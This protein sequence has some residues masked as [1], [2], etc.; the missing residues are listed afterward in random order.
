MKRLITHSLFGLLLAL[1]A[2]AQDPAPPSVPAGLPAIK[3][4]SPKATLTTFLSAMNDYRKGVK[5]D[6]ARLEE[7]L[8]DA[9]HCLNLSGLDAGKREFHGEIAAIH[10][11]EVI[12]RIATLKS[13]AIPSASTDRW[14]LDDTA[15]TIAK[16]SSGDRA[17]EYLFT[18]ETVRRARSLYRQVSHLPYKESSG[19]G[20]LLNWKTKQPAV[21]GE[22][23]I[24]KD[25]ARFTMKT[26]M[27]A[28]EDYRKGINEGDDELTDRIDA[29]VSC[30]SL[31]DVPSVVREDKGRET[32]IYLKE[33]IDRIIA[34]DYD[35]IPV[36]DHNGN[37]VLRFR[38]KSSNE[39]VVIA[40]IESGDQTGE[41]LFT[42][43]TVDGIKSFYNQIKDRPYKTGTGG[44]AHYRPDM[45]ERMVPE[46]LRGKYIL[47]QNWQ[48]AGLFLGILLGLVVKTI[49]QHMT[50]LVKKFTKKSKTDWDDKIVGAIE[51][52]IG[53]L[54]AGAFW[55]FTVHAL[56]FE[57]SALAVLKIIIQVVISVAFIWALY[58]LAD[59]LA[60]YLRKLT[61]KTD[62]MLDDHLVPLIK[63]ALHTFIVIF[64]VLI[65]VQ[66][67]GFNVMSLLAGL[68]L[69]GLAFA[70]AAK[71]TC[72]NFFGSIMILTDR[73]FLV[74]DAVEIGGVSGTVEQIG[75][76]STRLRTFYDSEVTIPNASLANANI[77]NL[78]RRQYRRQVMTLGLTYDTPPEKMEAFAEGVK[79]I[80]KN[81]P[82]T[83]KD[84][85]HVVFESYGDCSLNV[86]VYY[87][88]ETSS[89]SEELVERHNINLQILQLGAE[90]G[91]EFA[92]P[93]QTLHMETFPE[94]EPTR[95]VPP[96]TVDEVKDVAASF[97]KDG[98]NAQPD[99]S[100]IFLPPHKDPD[101]SKK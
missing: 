42:K 65:T 97:G 4:D 81:N 10:L 18:G 76:R 95:T 79:N 75:F 6:D 32:A 9:I 94:K 50:H 23:F 44:G 3:T 70:L 77:D 28:M 22:V 33:V 29:A 62:T 66:N 47:F 64:G 91:V 83:R 71:D 52:P 26:F 101:L 82:I 74:G 34:I 41:Y 49:V 45:V 20:A 85:F 30:L 96:F 63:R 89:R 84:Y 51:K 53:I 16:V 92:F 55:F 40:R 61:A 38:L 58:R 87:F 24:K 60:E 99:G 39:R 73:P 59:V 7:R 31:A 12:D 11:K 98:K 36:S 69:G 86:L 1:S 13:T 93:T 21:K 80:I 14:Q 46:F 43:Q 27:S 68:G 56:Q 88:L 54:G 37:P 72:A 90:L 25:N 17:G 78:G 15:I 5:T 8:E 100:G 2:L 57:G 48:W 35:M 67:L 19:Q